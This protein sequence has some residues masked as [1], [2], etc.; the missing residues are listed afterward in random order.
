MRAGIGTTLVLWLVALSPCT[1]PQADG[2]IQNL[3]R[4][5]GVTQIAEQFQVTHSIF[6]R[7]VR[8]VYTQPTSFDPPNR[9]VALA[10]VL[11]I[12]LEDIE[13]RVSA[14]EKE[15]RATEET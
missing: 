8:A 13:A 15:A 5:S 10:A 7:N 6:S 9:L 1:V 11:A 3:G 4:L 2:A 14:I 12:E